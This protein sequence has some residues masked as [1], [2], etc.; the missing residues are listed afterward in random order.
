MNASEAVAT[1]PMRRGSMSL[2][3]GMLFS[4]GEAVADLTRNRSS[5]A[6]S[7]LIFI[8]SFVALWVLY[9][10]RVDF[11]W[12]KDYLSDKAVRMH[13]G[14]N[15]SQVRQAMSGMS[16]STMLATAL[17]GGLAS[18][19][20]QVLIRT[21]YH[22]L[23][24]SIASSREV[25]FGT[26]FALVCWSTLP[27]TLSLLLSLGMFFAV[28][29]SHMAP[30][31]MSLTSLNA[32]L[33]LPPGSAWTLWADALDLTLLWTIGITAAGLTTLLGIGRARALFMAALPYL[34]FYGF[35][36]CL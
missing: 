32:V 9:Y 7:V 22:F 36:A 19:V 35:W 26:W 23:T 3:W 11:P 28:D 33:H 1:T 34:A 21:V 6:L 31:Q 24:A 12:L 29:T 16:L 30:S 14:I 5:L 8:V 13:P 4:P 25:P 10:Q 2:A 17:V 27:A 18:M 15:A 20:F